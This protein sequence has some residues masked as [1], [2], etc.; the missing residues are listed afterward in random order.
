MVFRDSMARC[1]SAASASAN[2]W[3]GSLAI[4]PAA[5]RPNSSFG[6][7]EHVRARRRIVDHRRAGQPDAALHGENPRVDDDGTRGG[8]VAD[9]RSARH[10]AIE[11]RLQRILA[12]GIEDDRNALAAG[13]FAHAL[14]DVFARRPR[15]CGRIHSPWRRRP[16]RRCSPRRSCQRRWPAPIGRRSGRRRRRRRDKGWFRRR[17]AERPGGTDTATVMPFIIS[18]EA[19]RSETASGIG[20]STA[21][22]MTRTSE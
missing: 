5:T 2:T 4:L 18:V 12:D 14:G 7:I 20:M 8:A 19:A 1:A 11:R 21:A 6:H 10:Q 15:W 3:P 16:F 22:G 17:S 13:D 9:Q